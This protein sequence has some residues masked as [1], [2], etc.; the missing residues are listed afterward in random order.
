[1]RLPSLVFGQG[2]GWPGAGLQHITALRPVGQPIS[3]VALVPV[4]YVGHLLR[5][6]V[7]LSAIIVTGQVIRQRLVDNILRSHFGQQTQ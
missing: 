1:M 7:K 3:P 2:L 6:L 5:Q 4:Q